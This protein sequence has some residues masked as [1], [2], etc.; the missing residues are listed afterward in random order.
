MQS[1]QAAAACI[2]DVITAS[3][4][5]ITHANKLMHQW[6]KMEASHHIAEAGSGTGLLML[7]THWGVEHYTQ[8]IGQSER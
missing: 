4:N 1:C 7:A 2:I 3:T 8:L 6:R 5:K